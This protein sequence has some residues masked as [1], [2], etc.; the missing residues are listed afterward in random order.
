MNSPHPLPL[1]LPMADRPQGEGG[2]EDRKF[3]MISK[4]TIPVDET[5][6]K[7][8]LASQEIMKIVRG[9]SREGQLMS[10][11]EVLRRLI[12]AEKLPSSPEEETKAFEAA[13]QDAFDNNEDLQEV[14]D[15][16]GLIHFCS[17]QYM[18]EAYVS[19]LLRKKGNPLV[20][21]AGVVRENSAVYPRPIPLDTFKQPPFDMTEDEIETCLQQMGEQ[22]DFTDIHRTTTSIGTTYLFS[23]THLEPGHASMLAEWLDVGQYQ[24]P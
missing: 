20:L 18:T 9:R 8:E 10:R 22:E 17:S 5:R 15:P 3:Q 4:T 6:Q 13:L 23:S 21:M 7:G 12:D 1:P 19:I 2:G 11:E 16:N 24:S 14:V